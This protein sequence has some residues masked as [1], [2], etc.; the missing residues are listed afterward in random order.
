MTTRLTIWALILT[1]ASPGLAR[2][3]IDLSNLDRKL[4]G[5]PAQILVLGTTHLST[6]QD[7]GLPESL[8]PVLDRLAAFKPDIIT[9]ERLSGEQCAFMALRHAA[10]ASTMNRYCWSTMAASASTG[11]DVPEALARVDATL[12]AWPALPGPGLRRHLA[13][14]FLSAG[15][16]P[17]ALVQW[18]RLPPTERHGGDGLDGTLAALLDSLASRRNEN[19]LLGARLAARLG[20]ERVFSVDDHTGDHLDVP[21]AA[22][23]GRAIQQAW[24]AADPSAASAVEHEDEL[25]KTGD[26]LALYRYINSPAYLRVVVAADFGAALGEPSPQRYGRIYVGGWETRNLR[27]VANVRAAFRK[28]PGARVLCI[29]GSSHKPWFGSLLGQMQGVEIVDAEGV[30]GAPGRSP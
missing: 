12:E 19:Y 25:V 17:S 24:N 4:A 9:I 15:D 16:S 28:L 2:A 20:L 13:S 21:D 14:L 18:L 22:A 27:M 3:Q 26:M 8:E 11:L 1:L 7:A 23:F 6:V 5:P 29:V 30:L 10:Y